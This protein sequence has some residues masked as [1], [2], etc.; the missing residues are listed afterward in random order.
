MGEKSLEEKENANANKTYHELSFFCTRGC[1]RFLGAEATVP[2]QGQHAAVW[3]MP[4]PVALE[5]I[6]LPAPH[7]DPP[8]SCAVRASTLNKASK[9]IAP[10]P[11]LGKKLNRSQQLSLLIH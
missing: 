3:F 4:S 1:P 10:V 8:I 5:P 7:P 9:A 2:P 6:I 11:A